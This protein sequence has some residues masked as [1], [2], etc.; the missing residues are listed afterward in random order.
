MRPIALEARSAV[1]PETFGPLGPTFAADQRSSSTRT[2]QA[3]G[4]EPK[5]PSLLR[6]LENVRP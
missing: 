4:W 3:L 6:D 1:P 5:H 2:R